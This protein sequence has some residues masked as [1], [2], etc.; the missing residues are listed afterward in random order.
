[1]SGQEIVALAIVAATGAVFVHRSF[2]RRKFS[3]R[4]DTPCGCASLSALPS[5]PSMVFHARK[6]GRSQILI[7]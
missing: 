5:Q 2:R 6:G 4:R 1:M 3:F 7:K